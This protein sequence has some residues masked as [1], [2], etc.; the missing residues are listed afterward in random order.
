M[1]QILSEFRALYANNT[2]ETIMAATL[3]EAADRLE[4]I[5]LPLAQITRCRVGISTYVPDPV[6]HVKFQTQVT[7]EGAELGG[8]LATPELY[9][10]QEHTPVIFSAIPAA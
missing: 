3:K 2:E 5:T 1:K 4:T 9:T 10:V 6:V 7:P 8:C